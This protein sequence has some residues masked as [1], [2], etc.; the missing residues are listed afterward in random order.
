MTNNK[1]LKELYKVIEL[2][3]EIDRY[4]AL[5]EWIESWI[6]TVSSTQSVISKKYLSTEF[7]DMIK[8]RMAESM[9]LDLCEVAM[10]INSTDREINSEMTVIRKKAN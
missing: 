2:D 3:R 7:A 8:I 4:H 6:E 9:A 1:A 5:S 10:F